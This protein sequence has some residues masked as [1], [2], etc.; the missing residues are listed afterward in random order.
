MKHIETVLT[1]YG[2]DSA[3]I[4][5]LECF[6]SRDGFVVLNQNEFEEMQDYLKE[7]SMY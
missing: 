1:N 6:E 3:D 7:F 5:K 4:G 2:I